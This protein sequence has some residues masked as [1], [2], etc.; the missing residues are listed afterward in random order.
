[1]TTNVAGGPER[2][3]NLRPALT[4]EPSSMELGSHVV[5]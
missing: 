5:S 1:M 2:G 3:V 4:V